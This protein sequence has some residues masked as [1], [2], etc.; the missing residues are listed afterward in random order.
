MTLSATTGVINWTPS[1]TQ[2]GNHDVV[3]QVADDRGGSD[4]QSFTINVAEAINNPPV[5]TSTPVTTGKKGELY[6]YDVEATDADND[7]LTFSLL[8]F[9]KKMEIDAATGFISWTPSGKQTGSHDVTVE[10]S[11]GRGGSDT[12]SFT[13]EVA[14]VI[15]ECST[16]FVVTGTIYEE[17]GR[18]PLPEGVEVTVKNLMRGT[19]QTGSTGSD[20]VYDVTFIDTATSAAACIGDE[21]EVSVSFLKRSGRS[22]HQVTKDDVDA[23]KAEIDVVLRSQCDGIFAVNYYEGVNMI[24]VPL[25]PGDTW[26]MSDLLE[27]IGPEATMIIWYDKSDEKFKTFMPSFREDSPN[28]TAVKGGEGYILVMTDSKKVTYK[29]EAWQR[30]IPSPTVVLSAGNDLTTPIFA[31]TGMIKGEYGS[32]L[33]DIQVTV[34]NLNTGQQATDVTGQNAESGRYVVTLADFT[35]GIAAEVDDT[36]LITVSASQRGFTNQSVKLKI[37]SDDIQ[38]ANVAFDFTVEPLPSKTVLLQNYPNPFNPETWLPYKLAQDS[39]VT[40]QIY[41]QNGQLIRILNLASKNAGIYMTKEKAAY[42]DGRD[43]LGEKV[44]SGVYF[45]TLQAGAFSATRKMVILK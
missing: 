33:N 41:H 3:V 23:N 43:S 37:T 18:T 25:D 4:T 6:T 2:A 29:G 27:H 13:I 5:I 39:D 10:V 36:F 22:I 9:P 14:K 8:T 40:I 7:A 44:A 11:D 34:R 32:Y 35:R 19:S 1:G 26:R 21:I 20:G 38:S 30:V 16:I 31:V 17:D 12:Q 15:D 45:Y 24:A 28:N 42:W